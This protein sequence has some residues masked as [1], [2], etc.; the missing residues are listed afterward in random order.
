M[1]QA[2]W[3]LVFMVMIS[4]PFRLM[5]APVEDPAAAAACGPGH[6]AIVQCGGEEALCVPEGCQDFGCVSCCPPCAPLPECGPDPSSPEC[7]GARC[8]CGS[9][10]DCFTVTIDRS[11]MAPLLGSWP[12]I[13]LVVALFATGVLFAKR[14][15]SSESF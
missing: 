13:A 15:L 7:S 6:L 14:R 8:S 9:G 5:A 3:A 1:K 11:K 10:C 4:A 12:L 2:Q